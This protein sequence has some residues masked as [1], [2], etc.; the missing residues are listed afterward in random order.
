MK[1]YLKVL[2]QYADFNGRARRQEY[3]MFVV[4][5]IIFSAAAGAID[6][7]L[8]TYM[9]FAGIYALALLIP[10]LAVSVRRLH[11]I[12]K[13][14]WMLLIVLIPAIGAIWLIILMATEG[15]STNNQYGANPKAFA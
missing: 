1:W 12:G 3:W 8:G 5:N 11:D 13:S 14:G 2:N 6:S 9:V 7:I 10:A 4:F 15:Q